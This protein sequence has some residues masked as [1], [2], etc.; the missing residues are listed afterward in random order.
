MALREVRLGPG[1]CPDIQ[2]G[3]RFFAALAFPAIKEEGLRK[4]AELAWVGQYLQNVNRIHGVSDP[5]A[6]PRLR[7]LVMID[8]VR[9]KK[10][11][12]TSARRL[13]DRLA[14][15]RSVVPWVREWLQNPQALPP[16]MEKF[17]QRQIALHLKG[18][19]PVAADNFQKRPLWQSRPVLHLA[20]ANDLHDLE[21]GE[22][23]LK[24]R[25]DLAQIDWFARVIFLSNVV[26]VHFYTDKRYG[27]REQDLL[28][29]V[30]VK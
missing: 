1:E 24:R 10:A 8:P 25:V 5:Y 4:E 13:R 23:P 9:C 15:A 6:D 3:A 16:G 27:V 12:R 29:L 30:W 14:A 17:S 18:G 20:V 11:L 7:E 2:T 22:S 26:K 28:H 21:L 19:D